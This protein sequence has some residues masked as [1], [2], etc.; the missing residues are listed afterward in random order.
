MMKKDDLKI[1]DGDEIISVN[2]RA[3]LK[4]IKKEYPNLEVI[5]GEVTE[6]DRP[7][8]VD[9][10]EMEASKIQIFDAATDSILGKRIDRLEKPIKFPVAVKYMIAFLMGA[11]SCFFAIMI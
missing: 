3:R 2:D 9:L 5:I 8:S 6:D 11:A 1:I 10:A 7:V 4:D